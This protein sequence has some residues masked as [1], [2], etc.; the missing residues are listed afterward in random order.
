MSPG[1]RRVRDYLEELEKSKEDRE[2][3]VREGLE[4]YVDLW[5]KAVAR[6]IVDLEDPVDDALGKLER[7]GGLYKAAE[8]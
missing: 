6:G 7:A 5:R 4:T 8:G 2:P 3:Q 1:L